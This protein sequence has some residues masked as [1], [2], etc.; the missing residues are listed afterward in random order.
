MIEQHLFGLTPCGSKVTCY[1][2]SCGNV[3][4]RTMDFGAT[5]LGVDVPDRSGA[6]ADIVLGFSS[7]E[8]YFDNPACYGATIGPSANRTDK[9]EITLSGTHYQMARNDG[10]N[11]ANN[12]HTDLAGGLHKRLW[13]AQA[14][15]AACAVTYTLSLCDGELGL[16]GNRTFSARYELAD[17]PDGVRLQITYG[18]TTD[19]ETFVNMTNH[20]YFNLGGHAAGTID[21]QIARIAAHSILALRPD[22]VSSGENIAVEGTPFDFTDEH[23]FGERVENDNEQLAIARGYDHCFC[24]DGF[25]PDAQA[26]PALFARDPESG[27]TLTIEITQPGAHLYTGN[28]LDD[29]T[30]KDDACYTPRC[31]FAFEPEYYPDCNHH[32]AWQ[33][34]VC[35][36]EHPYQETITYTFGT[37][38][39]AR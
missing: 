11:L 14:D 10:P 24:I 8:G 12:L 31:G 23:A 21:H 19:R 1:T 18:C 6:V 16:P 30:A 38:D 2:L 22:S 27:R 29:H 20:S 37:Y 4:V 26:R 7:L 25:A 36:P 9:G 35:T 3:K 28:W 17:A 32:P 34:P 39:P 13:N 5:L 15:E 33:Q